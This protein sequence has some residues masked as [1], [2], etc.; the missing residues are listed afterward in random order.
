MAVA[1]LSR[2]E[3]SR[4]TP[5]LRTMHR[6]AAALGVRAA[7]LLE[8]ETT[9]EPPDRCPVSLSGRCILDEPSQR[10]GKRSGGPE[11]FSPE[12]LKALRLCNLLLQSADKQAVRALIMVL[13]GLLAAEAGRGVSAGSPSVRRW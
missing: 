13:N 10:R 1:H 4:G 6:L 7:T 5:T 8:Q 9:L 3:N 11:S 12:D 2:L